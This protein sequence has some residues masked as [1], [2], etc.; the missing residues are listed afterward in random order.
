MTVDP[1]SGTRCSTARAYLHP[2]LAEARAGRRRLALHSRTLVRRVLFE[3]GA[4]ARTGGT[5]STAAGLAPRAVGVECED[6]A[7][8]EIFELRASKEVVLSLGAVGSPQTLMLS[9]VGDATE[10]RA[11]GLGADALVLHSPR[12]GRNLQDHYEVYLQYLCTQP[13]SLF[14]VAQWSLRHAH[15]RVRVGLE[16]FLRGTGVCASNQFETGAFFRSAAGVRHPDVQVHFI[17]GAVLGQLEFLPHHAFQL[18]VGTLRP[19]SRGQ[20]R[21]SSADPK[22]EPLID[23]NFLATEE[24]RRDMR[25][26]VRLSD[27]VVQTPAFAPFRGERLAPSPGVITGSIA[28]SSDEALDAWIRSSGHSAYHLSCTCAMGQVVDAR[29]R[30]MGAQGLRVVDASIMPSMTSGNLNAPTIMLAEKLADDILGKQPLAREEEPYF[31]H[32]RWQTE[33]R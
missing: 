15:T 23:P 17:P 19:T 10:L 4:G 26:A 7:T 13:V 5:A 33:Q 21:L 16:W 12:V 29:G 9:G 6:L 18:H 2:A 11:A 20:L 22:A 1:A 14:P 27:E 25:N 30:V 28:A 8:G 31:V 3:G 24:D 32:P